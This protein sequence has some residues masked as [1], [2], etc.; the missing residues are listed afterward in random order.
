MNS[1]ICPLCKKDL[2]TVAKILNA[3]GLEIRKFHAGIH[4]QELMDNVWN[5][6]AREDEMHSYNLMEE[7][8]REQ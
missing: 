5:R 7:W 4:Q 3:T 8:A 6:A 1:P 2:S